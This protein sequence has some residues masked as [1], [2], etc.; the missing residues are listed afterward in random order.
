MKKSQHRRHA[1]HQWII[2]GASSTIAKAFSRIAASHGADIL[3]TGRHDNDLKAMAADLMIRYSIDCKTYVLD[4][5][6]TSQYEGL[7]HLAEATQKKTHIFLA[8]GVLLD[9]THINMSDIQRM[10]QTNLVSPTM[11]LHEWVRTFNGT[12]G[13]IVTLGSVAGDRGRARN[14]IYGAA[15]SGLAAYLDGFRVK[16]FEKNIHVLLVKP[17]PID[18]QMTFHL[19]TP[20]PFLASPERCAK[21]CWKGYEK[22]QRVIYYPRV[23]RYVMFLVKSLPFVIFKQIKN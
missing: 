13:S 1:E 16:V 8:A 17:G 15:K 10:L 4:I 5:N 9:E 2:V 6:D 11:F 3:L 19:P 12:T 14:A 23:W 18:T 22:K 21:A 20:M 7:I